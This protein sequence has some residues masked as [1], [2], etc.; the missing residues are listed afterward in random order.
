MVSI[1]INSLCIKHQGRTGC[2]HRSVHSKLISFEVAVTTLTAL[3][4]F[5]PDVQKHELKPFR[6]HAGSDVEVWVPRKRHEGNLGFGRTGTLHKLSAITLWAFKSVDAETD[7]AFKQ[8]AFNWRGGDYLFYLVNHSW[9]LI[10]SL[11]IHWRAMF[12]NFAIAVIPRSHLLQVMECET[13][14]QR[15]AS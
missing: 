9:P 15:S 2:A 5:N 14:G 12:V 3:R 7:I 13:A 1:L 6:L 11:W 10:K 4:N 8:L